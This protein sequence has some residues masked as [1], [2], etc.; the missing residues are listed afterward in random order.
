MYPLTI[1]F[2]EE[3]ENASF[4]VNQLKYAKTGFIH[5]HDFAGVQQS[6]MD[7]DERKEAKLH[8]K[9]MEL[10]LFSSTSNFAE[11]IKLC[12]EYSVCHT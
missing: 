8:F 3:R 7:G 5:I 12:K 2:L 10:K 1:S 11:C 4:N 9:K 6:S